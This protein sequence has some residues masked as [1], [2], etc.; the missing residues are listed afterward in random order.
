GAAFAGPVLAALTWNAAVYAILSLTVV[1]MLPVAIAFVGT[2]AR[3]P[4]VGFVGW[5]GPRGLASI[6]FIVIVGD[7]SHLPDIGLMSVVVAP[8]TASP[9]TRPRGPPARPFCGPG[10]P[11]PPPPPRPPREGPPGAA[12]ARARRG[13]SA[14]RRRQVT[15]GESSQ[16]SLSISTSPAS[17]APNA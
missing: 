13:A 16:K 2:H 8:V 3:P 14:P 12:A 11:A 10:A 6:V 4:T 5:F 1:R 7:E 15:P 9:R 17:P